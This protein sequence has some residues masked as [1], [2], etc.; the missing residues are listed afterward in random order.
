MSLRERPPALHVSALSP[1]E[2]RD[3]YDLMRVFETWLNEYGTQHAFK[4]RPAIAELWQW[5]KLYTLQQP[6]QRTDKQVLALF[7]S[8]AEPE[9]PQHTLLAL[10]RLY[11]HSLQ[12]DSRALLLRD[13]IFVA[14]E[15]VPLDWSKLEKKSLHHQTSSTVLSTSQ[16]DIEAV[17]SLNQSKSTNPFLILKAGNAQTG[18]AGLP[19][20]PPSSSPSASTSPSNALLPASTTP[21]TA[22]PSRQ[23]PPLPPPKR[24]PS[25]KTTSNTPE[26]RPL[27]QNKTIATTL[28]SNPP[29]PPRKYLPNV[30]MKD[31]K[32]VPPPRKFSNAAFTNT[33]QN[34]NLSTTELPRVNLNKSL[35]HA[36]FGIVSPTASTSLPAMTTNNPSRLTNST[37]IGIG[38]SVRLVQSAT[39]D[40]ATSD[41]T[42][43]KKGKMSRSNSNMCSYG[44]NPTTGTQ[45]L[46]ESNVQGHAGFIYA[47]AS[48]P[49]KSATSSN[50]RQ[51]VTSLNKDTPRSNESN[52]SSTSLSS[53]SNSNLTRGENKNVPRLTNPLSSNQS[54]SPFSSFVQGQTILPRIDID[55]PSLLNQ[56]QISNSNSVLNQKY[57]PVPPPPRRNKLKQIQQKDENPF[58]MT[59]TTTTTTTRSN[60]NVKQ[61]EPIKSKNLL[62]SDVTELFVQNV[63]Q[64]EQWVKKKTINEIATLRRASSITGT[65]SS[66]SVMTKRRNKEENERLVTH[67]VLNDEDDEEDEDEDDEGPFVVRDESTNS[68]SLERGIDELDV[69]EREMQELERHVRRQSE[70]G[71]WQELA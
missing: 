54:M 12:L 53:S 34:G 63:K 55:Q 29:L 7:R 59:T 51:S 6:D 38:S 5:L 10:A 4:Q 67:V 49:R 52:S 13:L 42:T 43:T 62:G 1:D 8:A 20:P 22:H 32:P 27:N 3:Y 14:T 41:S 64:G 25:L 69:D 17:I 30:V 31:Q 24:M 9:Q 68:K 36:N 58:E 47:S 2:Y 33:R 57:K 71:Q 66:M 28:C 46:I 65:S 40:S 39:G 23:T 18:L 26:Q 19:I 48:S 21:A 60:L 61:H 15:P 45:S 16:D 37:H 50:K 44:P 70:R 56:S 35:S 11:S